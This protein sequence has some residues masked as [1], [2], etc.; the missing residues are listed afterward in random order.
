MPITDS[1]VASVFADKPPLDF[2]VCIVRSWYDSAF[3]CV[4]VSCGYLAD[5]EVGLVFV[6][7]PTCNV[8]LVYFAVP[9][10]GGGG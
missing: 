8:C 3:L 9:G 7:S 1:V 10:G 2:C 6:T 4:G 5:P